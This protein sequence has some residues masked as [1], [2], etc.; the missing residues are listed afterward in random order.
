MVRIIR[1]RTGR[2]TANRFD[3]R[4][5]YTLPTPWNTTNITDYSSSLD[6]LATLSPDAASVPLSISNQGSPG[7]GRNDD[8][9]GNPY[10]VLFWEVDGTEDFGFSQDT[11]VFRE[12]ASGSSRIEAIPLGGPGSFK[13]ATII[14]EDFNSTPIRR[15]SL[16]GGLSIET[17][18]DDFVTYAGGSDLVFGLEGTDNLYGGADNDVINGGSGTDRLVGQAGNDLIYG[19]AE[20]DL[21]QGLEGQDTLYGGTGDDALFGGAENDTLYGGL[22]DDRFNGD[23]GL[24]TLI[25]SFGNDYYNLFDDISD[26]ITELPGQGVDTVQVE[27]SY[28]LPANVERLALQATS[29]LIATGNELD[30][31]IEEL[32]SSVGLPIIIANITIQAGAGNDTVRAGGGDDAVDGGAGNDVLVGWYGSDT[33]TGGAGADQFVFTTNYSSYFS[34]TDANPG[35]DGIDTVTDF[36]QAQGDRLAFPS[37]QFGGLPVGNLAATAFRVGTAANSANHRF[38]YD[39]TTGDLFFD[40]DGLGGFGQSKI[41]RLTPGL[42]LTSSAIQIIDGFALPT[43][44]SPTGAPAPAV[45]NG[46]A[47]NDRL[48]GTEA[49]DTITALAGDDTVSGLEG[50]DSL[51]GGDGKDLL[52]GGTGNDQLLGQ[53]AS[54]RLYGAAGNDSLNGGSENDTLNGGSGNDTLAGGAGADRFNFY[55]PIT[56]GLDQISDFSVAED[57][58]GLY[59]GSKQTTPFTTAFTPNVELRPD[60]FRVGAAAATALERI[61]YDSATGALFFDPDGNGSA[62]QVQIATLSPGLGLTSS[63]L[64]GFDDGNLN[65]PESATGGNDNLGGGSQNDNL[66]GGGG[67]DDL[68]GNGGNDRLNGGPGND[69]LRGGEGNDTLLGLGGNDTL[70]GEAGNDTLN[71]G[72]GKDRL[73]GGLNS[74]SLTGGQ[75]HDRFALERGPG[76]DRILDFQNG[77]DRLGLTPGLRFRNLSILPRGRNTLIRAG[78]D[79]LALILDVRANQ[80]TA[81]DFVKISAPPTI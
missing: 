36:N 10:D 7:E 12:P 23:T 2:G 56:D 61:I 44:P 26:S 78:G 67:N 54:D 80:I 42:S 43:P 19:E 30:N 28:T 66:N 51:E 79:P 77:L 64:L 49:N 20:N 17:A 46:T 48:F 16:A 53:A 38:I 57:K 65:A 52:E 29:S 68:S 21:I 18:A 81:A 41:A 59:V 11:Y 8:D 14:I 45:Q 75:G 15:S 24:D 62:P 73:F 3:G 74:D 22:G 34:G 76:R 27:V 13:S 25:G 72:L 31:V 60:Q 50:D 47:G 71:G 40:R 1:H 39:A 35:T 4:L 63:N 58:I 69:I 5:D 6:I 70:L 32:T 37:G 33:L 9:D 55:S